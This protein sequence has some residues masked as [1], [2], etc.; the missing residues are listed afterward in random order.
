[1]AVYRYVPALRWKRGERVGLGNLSSMGRH[2]VIPLFICD[3]D[4]YVGKKATK[5]RAAMTPSEVVIDEIKKCWGTA[6]FYLDSSL[7]PPPSTGSHPMVELG[8]HARTNGLHLIPVTQL[9]APVQYQS[10]VADLIKNDNHGVALRTDLQELTAASLW[11]S[12]W[13]HPL[14]ETD[15]IAG[16]ADN[17]ATVAALG[18]ALDPAFRGLHG[19]GQWRTVTTMGS[20]M[21]DSFSGYH[22]GL[23]TI[24][25]SELLLWQRLSSI[26]L[27][28]QLDYGDYATV[29]TNPPPQG[30]AWGFPINVKYSLSDQF[31]V[32]RGVRTT[33][34]GHVD[35]DVQLREHAQKI[36]SYGS[37]NAL[38]HCWGDKKI[39][40]IAG[41]L[42]D[43]SGL[44]H[45][46]QIGVNRHVEVTRHCLA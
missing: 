40:G 2:K 18:A 38:A 14:S 6:P 20:S 16:F 46:V 23:Y 19:A 10:A 42:D 31:L 21:P 3:P 22:A 24:V 9:D 13:P 39:D 34:L 7:F 45:W 25:R 8:M 32:C 1:M 43:P 29:A 15:L 17:V 4:Q 12:S 41:G 28:Y 5:A 33:G 27:S 36:V 35:M 26:G 30:T 37:R 11:A 44:E